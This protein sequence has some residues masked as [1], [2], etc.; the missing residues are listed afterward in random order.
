MLKISQT[1]VYEKSPSGYPDGLF[2]YAKDGHLGD[3]IPGRSGNKE[4][5]I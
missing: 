1:L 4:R 3:V 2:G 5:P